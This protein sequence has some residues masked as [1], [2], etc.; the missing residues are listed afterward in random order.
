MDDQARDAA[1]Y[2]DLDETLAEAWRLLVRGAVDRRSGFH[3]VQLATVAPDGGPRVR[4]L[5]LRGADPATCTVRLHT[6]IRAEKGG[7]IAAEPRVEVCAYDARAKIQIRLRGK[8]AV[9]REGGVVEAAWAATGAGSRVC[10][11]AAVAP[12]AEIATPFLG[13]PTEAAR[14]PEDPEAG[15]VHFSALVIAV[16]RLDW[17]YLA[18]RGH[19]RAAFDRDGAG[20]RGRWLGP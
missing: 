9:H 6:D 2:D 10:Y 11:R 1:Y 16:E 18:A 17:L 19:R 20:W 12:G 15:R 3:T 8:A 4:T 14:N 7:Q 5:V 13:D